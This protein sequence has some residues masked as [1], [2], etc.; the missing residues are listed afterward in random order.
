MNERSIFLYALD[1]PTPAE[2]AAYLDQACG[3]DK[4]LRKRVDALLVEHEHAGSFL[5]S[6]PIMTENHPGSPEGPGSTV[7]PYKLLQ[8]IGEGGFG[9]V[10][11]AEQEHPVRRRIALKI[12]KPGMDSAQVIARFEAERQALAMM[13]H[14]NI[15]RVFDAGT[16]ALGHPYFVMELVHGIPITRYCD[17]NHLSMSERLELFIPICQAIQ[18]AHQKGIIHRDI[19]PANLLIT[20]YDG[21]PVAKVID[22]GV[23]KA[24]EQRLTD[25]TMFTHYGTVV[26]TLEYMAPEQAEMSALGVDTRSDIYSLGVVLYELLTGTTPLERNRFREAGFAEAVKMIKE[27]EPQRPSTRISSSGRLPALAAARKTEPGKLARVVRGELDWIVMKCLEKDRARRYETA[28]GLARDIQRHLDDEPVEAC[29]PSAAYKLRKFARKHRAAFFISLGFATLLLLGALAATWQAVRATRAEAEARREREATAKALARAQAVSDFL[30]KDLL[31]KAAPEFSP[32]QSKVTVEELL[33]RAAEKIDREGTLADQPEVEATLR[34]VIGYTLFKV[35]ASREA[36]PHLRRAVRIRRDKLGPDDA[37]TLAAQEDL[38]YF[39]ASTGQIDEANELARQTWEARV[40][41][42][43]ENHR[44]TLESLDTYAGILTELGKFEVANKYRDQCL[45]GR[46]R[47]GEKDLGYLQSLSN[48]GSDYNAQGRHAEAEPIIRECLRLTIEARGPKDPELLALRNNLGVALT[49]LGRFEES[50]QIA[51]DALILGR[52]L[53]GPRSIQ[54][55]TLQHNLVRSLYGAGKLDEAEKLCRE[56]I[57][58]RREA[59]GADNLGVG[60]ANG[61]L[62]LILAT[63]GKTSDADAAFLE[64]LA[65]LRSIPSVNHWIA[66]AE[67]GHAAMMIAKGQIG[68]AAPML[69][70]AWDAMSTDARVPTWS[71]QKMAELIAGAYEKAGV[72]EKAAEWRKKGLD[73]R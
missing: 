14:Q 61:F 58:A 70:R 45:E 57:V 55:L 9:I 1:K 15:A 36:G 11:M 25:R 5:E 42:L 73:P 64:A 43:G 62:G 59:L 7:G 46:R 19:K 17:E 69:S 50:V 51:R 22:F 54:T 12:V 27:E 18:H 32:H 41:V 35:G 4:E 47:F 10:Y 20:L 53:T 63:Q 71:R 39:L 2:R 65:I 13:D 60:R 21:K 23:A 26:G 24:T 38:A 37:D 56:T 31:G 16:T 28:N 3:N 8:R 29:P 72:P 68:E 67:A 6:S 40:R 66:E 30:T 44:D 48:R 33:L 52:Q 34:H 49:H